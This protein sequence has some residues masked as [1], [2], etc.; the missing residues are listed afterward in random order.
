M[1]INSRRPPILYGVVKL[2]CELPELLLL[3][4]YI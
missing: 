2:F 1:T 3:G 4:G